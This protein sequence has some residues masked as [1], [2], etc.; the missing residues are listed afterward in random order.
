MK[1]L[2]A[3]INNKAYVMKQGHNKFKFECQNCGECCTNTKIILS[4]YDIAR[5]S[6]RLNIETKEFHKNFTRFIIN[7]KTKIPMCVLK[8]AP[9]CTFLKKDEGCQIYDYRPYMCRAFPI[10]N[11]G[12]YYFLEDSYCKGCGKGEKK[13]IDEWMDHQQIKSYKIFEDIWQEFL[14]K[15]VRKKTPNTKEFHISFIRLLYDFDNS[16]VD[17]YI[18]KTQLKSDTPENKFL[19]L[20][21]IAE[22]LLLN[23]NNGTKNGT[24]NTSGNS[25]I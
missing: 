1:P 16:T 18:E 10:G 15:L 2:Y 12:K 14:A 17:K 11:F 24:K 20:I 4:P 5:L 19:A 6:F 22:K 23:G 7:A 3:K 25:N 8:T 13:S 9:A 21:G